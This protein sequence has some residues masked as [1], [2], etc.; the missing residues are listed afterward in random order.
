MAEAAEGFTDE[1]DDG[2]SKGPLQALA[3]VL[4]TD[5][6]TGVE[7]VCACVRFKPATTTDA[8]G[9]FGSDV[10]PL[11]KNTGAGSVADEALSNGSVGNDRAEDSAGLL[12]PTPPSLDVLL[13]S[14]GRVRRGRSAGT[15]VTSGK[16]LLLLAPGE[17]RGIGGTF[18]NVLS[19]FF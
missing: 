19:W 6:P 15:E 17:N 3:L 4:H 16:L 13:L 7:L 12:T 14:D 1:E 18:E 5:A 10:L 11:G 2:G 9:S 8:E